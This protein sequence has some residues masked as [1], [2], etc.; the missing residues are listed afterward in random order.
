[1]SVAHTAQNGSVQHWV[2][3]QMESSGEFTVQV[4]GVPEL[5]ATAATRAEA[6]ERIRTM[7]GEWLASL[8][9]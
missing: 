2:V 5:R 1:M 6:I 4:V 3:G 7:L 8:P 9:R